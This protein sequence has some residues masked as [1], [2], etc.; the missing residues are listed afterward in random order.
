MMV[1]IIGVYKVSFKGDDRLYIGSSVDVKRRWRDHRSRLRCGKHHCKNLQAAYDNYGHDALVFQVV[2][3]CS[4]KN[5]LSEERKLLNQNSDRLLNTITWC[6]FN[7]TGMKMPESAKAAISRHLKGN[8]YR[9]GIPHTTE[10]KKRI[11]VAGKR[12]YRLGLREPVNFP[13]NLSDYNDKVRRGE[14]MHPSC[15]PEQ[16]AAITRHYLENWSLKLAGEAFGLTSG[17]ASYAVLRHT[18]KNPRQLKKEIYYDQ[19]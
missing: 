7:R 10:T 15:K 16:D 11:S 19:R 5:L 17:A 3:E 2:T 1:K 9:K 4:K 8:S 12:A 14:V 6:T 13:E 18:G